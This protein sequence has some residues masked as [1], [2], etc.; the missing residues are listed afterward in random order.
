[1]VF[2]C[3]KWLRFVFPCQYSTADL[4]VCGF[5][6]LKMNQIGDSVTTKNCWFL[7][8]SNHPRSHSILPPQQS[9]HFIS[10]KFQKRDTHTHG[11]TDYKL[12]PGKKYRWNLNL[13]WSDFY[14]WHR[15]SSRVGLGQIRSTQNSILDYFL[16]NRSGH[17]RVRRDTDPVTVLLGLIT[18]GSRSVS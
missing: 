7:I 12:H 8:G 5:H 11:S 13:Y 10:N 15:V 9:C 6:I 1:M 3:F 16:L 4:L 2:S 14:C 18:N 17:V